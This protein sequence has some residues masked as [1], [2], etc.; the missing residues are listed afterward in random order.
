[1]ILTFKEKRYV[2]SREASTLRQL[3]KTYENGS[4]LTTLQKSEPRP[5]SP[6]T[7]KAL[8]FDDEPTETPASPPKP[9]SLSTTPLPV[10]EAEAPPPKPP[11][12][13]NPE[14]QAENTLKE[15]FPTID[16][17]VVKAVLR[18]SSGRVEPAF[19]ALLGM[20]DPDAAEPPPPAQPPR[21]LRAQPGPRS[22]E[23]EQLAA[24]ERYARQLAEHYNGAAAYDHAPRSAS[25]TRRAPRGGASRRGSAPRPENLDDERDRNFF[26]GMYIQYEESQTLMDGCRRST[27]HSRQH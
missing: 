25:G 19:N 4:L 12:P 24:D 15:A 23:E 1:M 3:L 21:P 2:R 16:A 10:S 27:S 18:A 17:A 9:T 26:D 5:E 20:S 6:T 22:A 13:L 14:Q 8:D 7:A 11:R